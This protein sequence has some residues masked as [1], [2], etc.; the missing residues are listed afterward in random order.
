MKKK[1]TLSGKK[2][3]AEKVLTESKNSHRSKPFPIVAIG[4][5]AGGIE[6]VTQLLKNLSPETGMAFVYIQ[7]LDPTHKSLLSSILSK[8]TKMPVMEAKEKMRIRANHVFVIPPDKDMMIVDGVLTLNPRPARPMIHMPINQFFISLADKQK[9][10]AIGIVLSGN[11]SDGTLGL[12]AI[13]SAGGFTFAQDASAKFQSMPKSAIAEG[14]VDM[15]LSPPEIAT[16]LE[17]LSKHADFLHTK[18]SNEREYDNTESNQSLSAILQLLHRSTGVDF[19]N[20]K[21]TT[22]Q[23][24]IERRMLLYKLDSLKSYH[25]YL[26]QHAAEINV[27]FNDLL[28]NVTSF[29][30]DTKLCNYLKTKLFPKILKEKTGHEPIRIWIPACSTGQEAY[31]IAMLLLE[32]LGNKI[33]NTPVQIF[34]SDL[35]ESAID[36]ARIGLYAKPEITEVSPARLLRFFRKEDNHYRVVKSI[37][38]LC[39]FAPHNIFRDPPFSRLDMVSCC[40]LLIYLDPVLQKKALCTFHYS[41]NQSGY[42]VL[43]KTESVGTDSILFAPLDKK[44]KIYQRKKDGHSRAAFETSFQ[45]SV[46]NTNIPR[47]VYHSRADRDY[48]PDLEKTIDHL[49]LNRYIPACVVVNEDLD[50][51]QFRGSTGLFLEPSPGKAS[52]NLLKMARAGLGFEMRNAI[53]KAS[54][55][56]KPVKKTNI[57]IKNKNLTMFVSIEVVPLK[58]TM[59]GRHFLIFFEEEKLKE[60]PV[61]GKL[62]D[63]RLLQLEKELMSS[64]EDMSAIIE[65]REAMNEELQSANE[66]VVSSNEELQSINEELETSKEEIESTNEE[67]QTINQELKSRNDQLAEAFNFADAIFTTMREALVVLDDECRIVRAN[68]RF[69]KLFKTTEEETENR[70]IYEVG[71]RQW[72]IPR[73]RE[74]LETIIPEN[75]EFYNFEV[76]H[77]FEDIGEKIMILNARKIEQPAVKKKLILLAIEYLTQ[78]VLAERILKERELWFRDMANNAPVMIW[79][80]DKKGNR[81]FFNKTWMEYS[82]RQLDDELG[83]SWMDSMHPDDTD[84]FLKI[85]KDAIQKE[86]PYKAEYRLRRNDGEFRWMLSSAKPFYDASKSFIGYIGTVTEIHDERIM[87]KKLQ[88][89]V[90]QR[91]KSLEDANINLERSNSELQQFAY[92]A[93]HDLQEPLRKI[94]TFIDRLQSKYKSNLPD[95]AKDFMDRITESSKRMSRLIDDLLNFSR[96]SRTSSFVTT[97]LNQVLKNVLKNFDLLIQQTNAE[98]KIES[99]PVI[100]A[101]PVQMMQLFHNLISNALK[102]TFTNSKPVIQISNHKLS[103]EKTAQ[104]PSL[105]SGTKYIE[106]IVCDNGIGF[107]QEFAE[108]IFSIFQRLHGKSEFPGTGIGLA[109]CKKIVENHSG[110]IFANSKEN[111]GTSMHV[112]LPVG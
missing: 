61:K 84:Q 50:I 86:I 27:L 51:L 8:N 98:I 111:E 101:V 47:H 74:L 93:S 35:S 58:S 64:R 68:R 82:G 60:I 79:T 41:L 52:L 91:T 45:P 105:N 37:R 100:E 99:L 20:Y 43:G 22:V 9:E 80:S 110:I 46:A 13:K 30:R 21:K 78:H 57:E 39:V 25:K 67:L 54:K 95:E 56:E 107:R 62:K 72:D 81:N 48:T 83:M 40:N 69:Y 106:I 94:I 89:S 7:H 34:A 88:Q 19:N 49:L 71:N 18:E 24:R 42:L 77:V 109:L 6:A 44:L 73:L 108:K 14:A 3:F 90:R 59:A 16:E 87:N 112:I 76:H 53:H 96:V 102:F 103:E 55:T 70:L 4:A 23:R 17:R 29:F 10:G 26:K 36:K 1:S 65:E 38:D 75:S 5:S 66:E 28:I 104:Y 15:I 31:S 85:Y 11:A 97:D 32:V 2:N 63:K 12:R 92:V 33:E